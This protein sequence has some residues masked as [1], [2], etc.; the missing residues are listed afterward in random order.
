VHLLEDVADE[1]EIR[2]KLRL[3]LTVQIS[4]INEKDMLDGSLK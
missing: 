3:I 2:E 1:R 4:A